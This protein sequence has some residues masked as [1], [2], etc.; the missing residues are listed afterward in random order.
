MGTL[1]FL[2]PADLQEAAC[3]DL[4]R[5]CLSGGHDHMPLATQAAVQNGQLVLTRDGHDSGYLLAPWEVP[6]FGGLMLRSASVMERLAPY[7]L[8]QELARGTIN[9]IRGQTADWLMGGLDMSP[10]LADT[11][12]QT[13]L[14]FSKTLTGKQPCR[15]KC[16]I[17]RV[18]QAG[19][20]GSRGSG[21]RLCP[22]GVS[23]P[24]SASAS[25]GYAAGL[26][27]PC[28]AREDST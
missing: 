18:S 13:T 10:E 5:A 11:I 17:S 26:S 2:L 12:R 19:L 25:S 21:R 27:F 20:P 9:Q 24:P 23:H 3:L 4:E 22:P 1:H 6:G 16:P 15:D 7:Y 14:S 28:S 8:T